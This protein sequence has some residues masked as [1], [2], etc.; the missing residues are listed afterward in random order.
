MSSAFE[1]T[2]FQSAVDEVAVSFAALHVKKLN[3]SSN[4][5]NASWERGAPALL[6]P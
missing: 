6:H 1:E 4:G 5:A 2:R 3:A